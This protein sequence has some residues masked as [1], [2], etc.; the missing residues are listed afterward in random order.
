MLYFLYVGDAGRRTFC[1]LVT[2]SEGSHYTHVWY[3]SVRRVCE[4]GGTVLACGLRVVEGVRGGD[5]DAVE[6]GA[7]A[8]GVVAVTPKEEGVR[9]DDGEAHPGP[10]KVGHVGVGPAPLSGKDACETALGVA[11]VLGGESV[12]RVDQWSEVSTLGDA[13]LFVL[14]DLLLGGALQHFVGGGVGVRSGVCVADAYVEYRAPG[15]L[16]EA[17]YEDVS[18]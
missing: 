10:D 8:E 11:G 16:P 17:V 5:R 4:V 13:G 14:P 7:T 6:R 18:S 2:H 3:F 1:V 12:N 15:A 9:P